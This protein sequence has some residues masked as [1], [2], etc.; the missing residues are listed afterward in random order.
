MTHVKRDRLRVNNRRTARQLW[1]ELT[2]VAL[3][4]L[5]HLS[6]TYAFSVVTGDCIWLSKNWYVTHSGLLRLAHR[7]RCKG[8]VV[9]PQT[10][11]C[12]PDQARWAFKAVVYTE[13]MVK[14]F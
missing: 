11:L 9:E 12:A 13:D 5:N 14:G 7:R 10:A 2:S 8:I 6:R 4:L 3:R 1:P